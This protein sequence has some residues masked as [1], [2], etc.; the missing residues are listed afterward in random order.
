MDYK[1]TTRISTMPFKTYLK[2]EYCHR[3]TGL[4]TDKSDRKD[5]EQKCS[6]IFLLD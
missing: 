4:D 2:K 1:Y 3:C 5:L 6:I